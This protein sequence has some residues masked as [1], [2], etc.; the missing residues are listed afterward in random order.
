MT[1]ETKPAEASQSNEP[2]KTIKVRD[3]QIEITATNANAVRSARIRP[4]T[5]PPA[6]G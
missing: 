2:G 3:Y 1:N 6:T 5:P 4:P